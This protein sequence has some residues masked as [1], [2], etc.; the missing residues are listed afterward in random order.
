MGNLPESSVQAVLSGNSAGTVN[1]VFCGGI[2][3]EATLE[4]LY[5]VIYRA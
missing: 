5:E 4:Q 1:P 2:Y 3:R